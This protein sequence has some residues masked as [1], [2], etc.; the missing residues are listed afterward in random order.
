VVAIRISRGFRII[1]A[2]AAVLAGLPPFELQALRCREIYLRTRGL[3]GGVGAVDAEAEARARRELLDR[4]RAGAKCPRGH[5]SKL[6]CLVGGALPLTYR[7]T[8]VLTGH[9]CFGEYLRGIGKRGDQALPPLRH[10]CELGAAHAG[11]LPG[12]GS[13]ATLSHR[14]NRMRPLATGD[15]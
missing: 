6:G 2:A 1:S 5:P 15:F 10:K 14:G 11:T 8:D 13:A 4:W 7:L 12:V 3:L 9:E